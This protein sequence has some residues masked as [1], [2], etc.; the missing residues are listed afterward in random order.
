MTTCKNCSKVFEGN[1][2]PNCSQRADTSRL[3]LLSLRYDL[4][5]SVAQTDSGVFFLMK[6]LLFRPGIVAREFIEGKRRKYF[7]PLS[8]LLLIIMIVVVVTPRTAILDRYV[9]ELQ[10][11]MGKLSEL[12]PK[13]QGLKESIKELE[14][15]K[16]ESAVLQENQKIITLIFLP[17]LSLFTWVM[18]RKTGLNYAE[19][20]VFHIYIMAQS[21]LIFLVICVIPFMVVPSLV[22]LLMAATLVTTWIYD[23][24]AYKQ[25]YQESWKATILKGL[26]IQIA[27]IILVGQASQAYFKLIS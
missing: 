27:Y 1:F 18:F 16:R 2:C 10:Y 22:V 24:I 15:K 11:Y 21:M 8:Y 4:N 19:N 17:I 14:T 12:A 5:H 23:L 20:V 7:N 25:F 6:E 3:T 13:D 26:A 9:S